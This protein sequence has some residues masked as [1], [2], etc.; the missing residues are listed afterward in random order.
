MED[1]L[2]QSIQILHCGAEC[3]S[4]ACLSVRASFNSGNGESSS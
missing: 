2:L 1:T 4:P 3:L